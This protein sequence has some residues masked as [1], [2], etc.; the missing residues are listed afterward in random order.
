MINI[1]QKKYVIVFEERY[2]SSSSFDKNPPS[3]RNIR[4][5]GMVNRVHFEGDVSDTK[6]WNNSNAK[7]FPVLAG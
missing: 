6:E 3:F 1:L 4:K 5:I 2:G 7:E